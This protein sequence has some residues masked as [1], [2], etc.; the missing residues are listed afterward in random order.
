MSQIFNM[1]CDESCH[2]ENDRQKAMVLGAVWCPLEKTR[3]IAIR[4]REIKSKHGMP[5]PFE[6]KWTKVS[7]AKKDLY[8]D[9]IDYFFDDDD[10]HFR[11]LIVPEKDKLN[12]NSFPGQDHDTWYYKMYFDMIKVILRPDAHYRIYLDI[13]DT[14]GAAKVVKLHEV[15]CNNMYDFSREVI[16]QLQLVHSH[17]IEQLQLADLLIGAIS[18][19]NRGLEGNAGKMAIIQRMIKRSGYSLTKTTLL[20]EEKINLFRWHATEVQG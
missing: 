15:L 16:E 9:L 6:V 19:L 8:L 1:Y 11:A 14:R 12:H 7:P 17:E 5:I 3:E 2:L 13:K 20:K 18:Y 10:L 4:L